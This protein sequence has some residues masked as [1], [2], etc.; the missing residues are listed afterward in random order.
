MPR[1]RNTLSA[2]ALSNDPGHLSA[3]YEA[4]GT[5]GE[6]GEAQSALTRA[7]IATILKN[8]G[9]ATDELLEHVAREELIAVGDH[10]LDIGHDLSAFNAYRRAEAKDR[11]VLL[12]D[13]YFA[14]IKNRN[15]LA[16]YYSCVTAAEAYV[17]TGRTGKLVALADRCVARGWLEG[18]RAVYTAAGWVLPPEKI[19]KCGDVVLAQGDLLRAADAYSL[20]GDADRLAAIGEQVLNEG[21]M[22]SVENAIE[23]FGEAGAHDKLVALGESHLHFDD[24]GERYPSLEVAQK[25]YAAAGRK[26]P[27]AKLRT[28]GKQLLRAGAVGA[29]CSMLGAAGDTEQLLSLGNQWLLE[30]NLWY[31]RLAYESAGRK[32]PKRMLIAC[33]DRCMKNGYEFNANEAYDL[34]CGRSR[35][36]TR[37]YD[38]SDGDCGGGLGD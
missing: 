19:I 32:I 3:H 16:D 12:G 7:E 35:T 22:D 30:G 8:G 20:A 17:L 33:G 24:V 23:I 1:R 28:A 38:A 34:A 4:E 25:A 2:D 18:A 27:K 29:A 9:Y 36:A 37:E 15:D 13:R 21:G 31:G 14:S 26:I 5:L 11:L 6:Q 10:L